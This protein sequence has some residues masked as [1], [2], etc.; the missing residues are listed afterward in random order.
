MEQSTLVYLDPRG[1]DRCLSATEESRAGFAL[2][3]RSFQK[4]AKTFDELSS[5]E[6]VGFVDNT[7]AS[8]S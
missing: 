5:S 6:A 7:L 3:L 4:N 1:V 8:D 2:F